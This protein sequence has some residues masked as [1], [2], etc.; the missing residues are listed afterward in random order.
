MGP[1]NNPDC[2]PLKFLEH[3]SAIALCSMSSLKFVE[4]NFEISFFVKLKT[5]K[6]VTINPL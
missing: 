2:N 3:H 5:R 6:D 4:L 1:S